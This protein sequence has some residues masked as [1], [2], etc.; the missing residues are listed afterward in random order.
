MES[1]ARHKP[2]RLAENKAWREANREHRL[3]YLR[4]YDKANRAK[5]NIYVKNRYNT[6]PAYRMLCVLRATIAC[7]LKR[8]R[9]GS[10]SASTIKL[11]GCTISSFMLY[12]ESKFE[13]GMSWANYGRAW[14]IDHELPCAMFDLSNPEH[15]KRCF[16]FSN[17]QPMFSDENRLKSDKVPEGMSATK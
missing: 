6:D 11:L 1:Y 5:R 14:E 13:P 12:I 3:K 8:A 4:N 15:Q 17:L 10:K 7:R 16:H 9:A 2:K